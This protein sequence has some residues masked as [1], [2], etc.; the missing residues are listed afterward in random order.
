LTL[1]R[2]LKGLRTPAAELDMD[3]LRKACADVP[4]MTPIA[5]VQPR[6]EFSAVGEISSLRIVPRAGSPSL[7]ATITDG[8]GSL[9]AVWTGRRQI[10]GV[11]PGRRLVVRG[12]ANPSGPNGRVLLYNPTYDLL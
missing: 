2:M 7:E 4:G 3:R 11:G 8:T 5:E 9:T 10:A 6:Q 1:K 12:R